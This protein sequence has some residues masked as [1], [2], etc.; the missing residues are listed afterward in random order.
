MLLDAII[1]LG[2]GVEPNGLPPPTVQREINVALRYV[3]K[4]PATKILFSGKHWGLLRGKH[5]P[6]EAENMKQYAL[7]QGALANQLYTE[8][9]SLDTI[10]NAI[11]S[12]IIVDEQRWNKLLIVATNTHLP[13]VRYIFKHVFANNYQLYFKSY[14]HQ[15]TAWQ[16]LHSYLHELN[17]WCY[18]LFF[19][20]ITPP[21]YTTKHHFMYHRSMLKLWLRLLFIRPAHR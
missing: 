16:Q 3:D 18:V 15:P 11:F 8:T 20:L 21:P 4:N 6:I 12:K 5:I 17:A 19:F 1:I 13:R 10:S 2:K 14:D 9:N 7:Q